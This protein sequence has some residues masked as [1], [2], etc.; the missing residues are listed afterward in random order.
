MIREI[1]DMRAR[2]AR[3]EAQ[4]QHPTRDWRDDGTLRVRA[5][6]Q[7]D[8]SWTVRALD[9]GGGLLADLLDPLPHAATLPASPHDGQVAVIHP[10][11]AGSSPAWVLVWRQALAGGAG[12]WCW[13]GGDE[14]VAS[15]GAGGTQN[16]AAVTTTAAMVNGPSVTIPAGMGGDYKVTAHGTLQALAGGLTD[17]IVWL[18]VNGT[19][20]QVIGTF[21]SQSGAFDLT[22]AGGLPRYPT[23]AAGDVLALRVGTNGQ[24]VS[25]GARVPW[26][27]L[28]RPAEIRP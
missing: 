20:Q 12:A 26:R 25:A 24:D 23:L 1:R 5:G 17:C 18:A 4:L 22:D 11:G 9:A 2:L 19:A 8:G 27:L 21:T 16:T 6:R 13:A 7:D 14:W 28:V 3:L 15:Q 10:A